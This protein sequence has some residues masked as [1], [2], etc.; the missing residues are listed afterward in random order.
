MC[1]LK[2]FFYIK[3][4]FIILIRT[5]YTVKKKKKQVGACVVAKYESRIKESD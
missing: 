1:N 2:K 4:I 3:P 5:K